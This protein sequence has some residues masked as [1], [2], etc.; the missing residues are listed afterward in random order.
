MR[1]SVA[2]SS[3]GGPNS[4]V[5][6]EAHAAIP[7]RVSSPVSSSSIA[8]AF[9]VTGLMLVV[10][11]GCVLYARRRGWIP[12]GVQ[13]NQADASGIEVK[14]SKRVSVSSTIHLIG[15][16]GNDYFLLESRKGF[17]STLI[18]AHDRSIK[19]ITP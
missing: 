10:I 14:S 13:S 18:P 12:G 4:P 8:T 11:I 19:E 1:A 17:Q 6:H 7:Y 9:A 15:Y 5:A 16:R 3:T 2:S